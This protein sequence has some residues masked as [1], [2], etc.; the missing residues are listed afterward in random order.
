[1]RWH[2]W[3]WI[4]ERWPIRETIQWGLDEEVVGGA[5]FAY[6]FGSINLFL[7]AILVV[8]GVWQFFYYVPTTDHAYDSVM[9]LRLHVQL[10]WLVHGLH[11]WAAQAFVVFVALHMTRVFLWGAYKPPRQ[12]TWLTGS[13]LLSLVLAMV[14]T[15]ALLAWDE[16]GYWAAEVGTSIAGTV[17]L[18]GDFLRRVSRGGETMGQETLSRFFAAHVAIL[19][20]LLAGVAAVHVAAFRQFG[21]VGPWDPERR[22]RTGRFWPDQILRDLLL[23]SL[24]FVVL[25]GLCAYWR[26]PITGPADPNDTAITPKPDWPFL[27]LYQFLKM[28]NGPWE[29]VGTVVVPI[30]SF[31]IVFL[32]PFY[33]RREERNPMKRPYAMAGAAVFTVAEQVGVEHRGAYYEKAGALRD[34]IQNHLMQLLCLMAMEPMVSFNAEPPEAYETLL[35]DVMRAEALIAQDG[36]SWFQP[37]IMEEQTQQEGAS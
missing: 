22:R 18:I 24:V 13:I 5:T 37:T 7:L 1:M 8:T 12:L 31:L 16:L 9:Y 10:G 15:G 14:F 27:F 36:R 21:N 17:P 32:L 3:Q 35:L 29:P 6:S 2:P 11:Y 26:A 20:A 33:D 25:A 19:P 34:M 28:F 4:C 23:A 30:V